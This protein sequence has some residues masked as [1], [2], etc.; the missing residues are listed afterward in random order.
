M[1]KVIKKILF[2]SKKKEKPKPSTFNTSATYWE[3]RYAKGGDSGG[4]SYS[5][6][7]VFK[8][9]VLNDFVKKNKVS[10]VIEYG[11]GDGNQL[12][13]ASYPNYI[14]FDVS[15]TAIEKCRESFAQDSTKS[16]ELVSDYLDQKADLT[17][18]LDVIFHL[19]E[20]NIFDR[21]MK[22]LFDSST[23]FVIVYA[24][25]T[26]DNSQNNSKHV[27][28]RLFT[29]WVEKHYPRWEMIEHVPNEYPYNGDNLNSSFADFFIFEKK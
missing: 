28:H 3:E 8:A 7:A 1:M 10:S 22:N 25:N 17:L 13:L 29:S 12:K 2:F 6:L 24:S 23:K 21:Y 9:K 16:F 4:G 27:K 18:S 5:H 14:G 26:N 15:K 20:D 11:S 19:V